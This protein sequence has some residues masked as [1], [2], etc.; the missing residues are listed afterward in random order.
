MKLNEPRAE[1]AKKHKDFAE[2][3]L[4]QGQL[5]IDLTVDKKKYPKNNEIQWN[6]CDFKLQNKNIMA[7]YE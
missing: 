7:F 1:A 6:L 3:N 5:S 4:V 2:T